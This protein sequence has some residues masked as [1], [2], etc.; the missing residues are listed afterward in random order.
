[1]SEGTFSVVAAQIFLSEDVSV[2]FIIAALKT[3]FNIMNNGF[4]HLI[5]CAVPRANVS[6]GICGQPSPYQPAHPRSLIRTFAV[7]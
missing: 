4:S 2:C 1:M 5:I 6:S 7:H 3:S